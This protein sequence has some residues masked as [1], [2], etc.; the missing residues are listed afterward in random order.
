MHA[1]VRLFSYTK[2][3][4]RVCASAMRSCYSVHSSST[5]FH[6]KSGER[7]L[8]NEQVMDDERV[9]YLIKKAIELGHHDI[10]EHGAFTFDLKGISRACSHQL[11]RH[12]IAS[13]SQQSQ[14]YVKITRTFGYI[15]PPSLEGKKV[16]V[17]IKGREFELTFEDLIDICKMAEE[18]FVKQGVR[19]EDA[20]YIRPNASTTNIAVTMNPRELLH[21]F[22]LRCALD[23]QW[24][25]RDVAWAMYACSRLVAPTIFETIPRIDK[26]NE[27]KSKIEEVG[28]IVSEVRP[29]FYKL[30][31]GEALEIPLDTLNLSHKVRAFVDFIG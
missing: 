26:N 29:K 2:N 22:S 16:R 20:R 13:Y 7:E 6:F 11:V 5:L 23:A 18:E 21:V 4:E 30:N 15:K 24:E 19:A 10:L 14:R 12:R 3:V 25:I 9:R 31:V 27:I 17:I 8:K 1:E 28:K